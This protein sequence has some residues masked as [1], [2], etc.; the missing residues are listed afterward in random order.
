MD[1]LCKQLVSEIRA[2]LPLKPGKPAT[3]D[4]QY[5]R[6]GVGDV[7]LFVE[8]LRGI[9]YTFV[10]PFRTKKEWVLTLKTVIETHYADAAKIR[11]V[12]D[13]LNTHKPSSFYEILPPDQAR[14]L[15][16]K[17]EF[18]YTPIHASWLNIAE[19]EFSVL[20]RQCLK[21]RISSL[22]ILDREVTAWTD[23][24]NTKCKKVNW[25]FTTS[26]ARIK[27]KQLYPSIQS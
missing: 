2:G 10:E 6:E 15:L 27:L 17:L 9:R 18:H 3:F 24:R 11:I 7:F 25:Q 16:D 20:A 26:D 12:L 23:H 5:K 14:S 21:K 13:N 19:S 1:E 8:P 4:Y 22:E